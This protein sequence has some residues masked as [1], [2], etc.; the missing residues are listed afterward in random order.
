MGHHKKKYNRKAKKEKRRKKSNNINKDIIS[1]D[2]NQCKNKIFKPKGLVNLGLTCYMNSLLQCFFYINKLR[3]YFISN[4]STFNEDNP[5]CKALS[6]IMYELKYSNED[7]INPEEL[8]NIIAKNNTLFSGHKANDAKDLFFTLI[9]NLLTELNDNNSRESFSSKNIDDSNRKEAF[10]ETEKEIDQKNIINQIFLAFY[11]TRYSCK[12]KSKFIYSFQTECFILFNLENI[13][14]FYKISKDN[15]IL[16]LDLCFQYYI[17]GKNNSSFYCSLCQNKHTN[18]SEDKIY[19]PPEILTIILDRGKGK[20]FREKVEFGKE[21]NLKEYIDNDDNKNEDYMYKLIC[22][23]THS[24]DSSSSGHYTAYCLNDNGK[25]YY[26][27]DTYVKEITNEKD[28]YQNEPYLLFYKKIE[29]NSFEFSNIQ[30]Q[31][32]KKN[33]N[34]NTDIIENDRRNNIDTTKPIFIK[35]DNI[36][37]SDNEND[38][39]NFK[40]MKNT[41]N[42]KE[43][44]KLVNNA[45]AKGQNETIKNNINFRAKDNKANSNN[46]KDYLKQYEFFSDNDAT[47]IQ[48]NNSINSKNK[49][50]KIYNNN[51][52]H[53]IEANHNNYSKI[54][55]KYIYL[56]I[57][58]LSVLLLPF[59]YIQIK[60]EVIHNTQKSFIRNNTNTFIIESNDK[61][62][63]NFY[64]L[65][66]KD[67]FILNLIFKGAK[68][69]Q[70]EIK[71]MFIKNVFNKFKDKPLTKLTNNEKSLIVR[72][73]FFKKF[74][75]IPNLFK[76]DSLKSFNENLDN[77]F[78]IIFGLFI[79]ILK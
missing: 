33:L 15:Y 24:G 29:K 78:N 50:G 10:K 46:E 69:L 6:N 73:Q 5:V 55:I 8:K 9:D 76:Y 30:T 56:N 61:Q 71:R 58:L 11:Y 19:K 16:S 1:N 34:L 42:N 3:E 45:E 63:I 65:R 75:L 35:D 52:N 39:I 37:P 66:Q 38:C 12:E 25:Y 20:K 22:I 14:K 18:Y 51:I 44:N 57:V 53:N 41:L 7:C 21:I 4:R 17:R 27:S 32:I 26:F 13:K 28:L 47:Y 2:I 48:I 60:K 23:C 74:N 70:Y 68:R 36:I 79:S 59:Y 64:F 54:K 62:A 31:E 67:S 43:E 72:Q 49:K 77:Y 40:Y